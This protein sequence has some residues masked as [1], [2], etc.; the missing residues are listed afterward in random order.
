MKVGAAALESLSVTLGPPVWIQLYVSAWPSGSTPEPASVTTA[1]SLTV[2]S[3]PAAAVGASLSRLMSIVT[4]SRLV[5]VPSET[6]SWKVTEVFVRPSGAVNVGAVEWM[7]LSETD[8]P[9]V[10]V[11]V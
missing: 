4:V 10:C 6:A 8:G 2:W 11:H 7:S 9:A 3:G 5:W 1:F